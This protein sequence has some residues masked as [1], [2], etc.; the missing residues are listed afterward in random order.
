MEAAGAPLSSSVVEQSGETKLTGQPEASTAGQDT[1]AAQVAELV[2]KAAELLGSQ[3]PE[4]ASAE[5]FTNLLGATLGVRSVEVADRRVAD[6]RVGD[7]RGRAQVAIPI[8]RQEERR[9]GQRR[10]GERRAALPGELVVELAESGDREWQG[11]EH[12]RRLESALAVIT[13]AIGPAGPELPADSA[14]TQLLRNTRLVILRLGENG[15]AVL[16]EAVTPVLGY[17]PK[18]GLAPLS[19]VDPRDRP[20]ALRAY[21]LTRTGLRKQST[22]ELRVRTAAD[23]T[24]VLETVFVDL[25]GVPGLRSVVAYGIDV[26]RQY[27]GRARLREVITGLEGAAMVTD[28]RGELVLAN[29]AFGR[30]FGTPADREVALRAVAAQCRAPDAVHHRLTDLASRKQ[31][32]TE[33]LDLADGRTLELGFRPLSDGATEL[34]TVWLFTVH[35]AGTAGRQNDLLTTVSHELRTSLT[36]LLGFGQLLAD[37]RLGQLNDTQR[38]ALDVITGNAERLLRLVDNLLLLNRLE[39]RQL[40]LKSDEV[41]VPELVHAALAERGLEADSRRVEIVCDTRTGP[42]LRGDTELLRQVLGN[43]LGNALKFGDAGDLVRVTAEFSEGVWII[44]I[45]DP[46]I[47]TP[48]AELRRATRRDVRPLPAGVPRAGISGGGLGLAVSRA[49]VE[50]HGGELRVDSVPGAGTTVRIELP[51]T[52]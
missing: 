7:R 29:G 5:A 32:S 38:S 30:E 17:P 24:V 20:A 51:V 16:S 3:D 40:P 49:V 31:P 43:A 1:P 42:P 37:V 8:Q 14:I 9:E 34:G 13:A 18:L 23:D 46:G 39:N 50:L 22:V 36:A 10:R 48:S 12:R 47:G 45:T 21:A 2:V 27:S 11:E 15:A 52:R 28:E 35:P 4:P 25:T 44:E 19:I 6:R 33:R 41:D 26:T